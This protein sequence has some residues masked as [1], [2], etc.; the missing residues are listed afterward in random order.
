MEVVG[1]PRARSRSAG[2]DREPSGRGVGR[3]NRQRVFVVRTGDGRVL[4]PPYRAS[5]GLMRAS[6]SERRAANDPC[7]ER[8]A[9]LTSWQNG[10]CWIPAP[11][12]PDHRCAECITLYGA[13]PAD[14]PALTHENLSSQIRSA[15]ARSRELGKGFSDGLRGHKWWPGSGTEPLSYASGYMEAQS[16][17]GPGAAPQPW[18]PPDRR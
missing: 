18:S 11:M 2:M 16:A 15:K 13:W 4:K 7:R 3:V 9:K 6:G 5:T 17:R 10:E 8:R 12:P 14:Q 1:P